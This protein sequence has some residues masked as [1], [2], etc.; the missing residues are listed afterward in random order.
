M[1][2]VF[3]LPGG[4]RAGGIKSTVMAANGLLRRGHKVRL[5]A[6]KDGKNLRDLLRKLMFKVFYPHN[7]DWLDHFKGNIDRFD[8]I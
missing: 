5:L 2:I 4:G 8:D 1:N 3:I 7:N 6:N